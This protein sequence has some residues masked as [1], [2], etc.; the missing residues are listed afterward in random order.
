MNCG[1]QLKLTN[2]LAYSTSNPRI[3]MNYVG[4]K[5][6]E[7]KS[8]DFIELRQPATNKLITLVPRSTQEE[9][10]QAAEVA[11]N[12]FKEWRK[13][14]IPQ[15]V[16]TVFEYRDRV[17]KNLD[18]IAELITHELGKTKADAQGDVMRGL[19]VAEY[20]ASAATVLL[21]D[22]APN[23]ASSV[24]VI[25]YQAPLGVCAGVCPFNF[26]AMIPLWMFPT[27]IV[28]GNS[29]IL[30]PSEKDPHAAELLAELTK[31][32]WPDGVMNIIQGGKEAVDF[33]CDD[34][35]IKAISFVGGGSIGN[36]IHKRGSEHGK[37]VQSN[38]AAKNHGVILPDAKKERT[39]DSLAGAAFG[40]TGQRCM[41]LPVAIFVGESQAWIPDLVEKAKKLTV[42]PG[43]MNVDIGPV[44]TTDSKKRIESLIQSGI[45]QGA[46]LILDG[47][48]PNV[49]S[50]FESGNYLGPSILDHVKPDMQCYSEEI[51]GP[52]LSIVRVDTLDDAI[53]LMN[54]NPYGN[55]CAV[56]TN[57]GAAARKFQYETEVGQIGINLP[58]P[59]PPPFFS[60]TGSKASF[61]GASNFYGK[62]GMK[63]YTQTKTVMSNWGWLDDLSLGVR[64]AM[65]VLGQEHHSEQKK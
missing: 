22:S 9:M 38:M 47:R 7:S 5:F 3:A 2:K 28:A 56:F 36:Y 53:E 25:S 23:V 15:R 62:N 6:V 20:C 19:E 8:K 10:N 55:G 43:H 63:F 58:I 11:H 45:E 35:R 50:G 27:A 49:P 16:R 61:L 31:G 54:N 34:P 59:V 51:F 52:V 60:F 40:A 17:H 33:I 29:F 37:K 26:P 42:G 12:A 39:L 41:A 30:K 46:K 4:G 57:S 44:V 18:K 13:V 1:R 14:P 48:K 65:P 21:G 32:I 64:T 24:D